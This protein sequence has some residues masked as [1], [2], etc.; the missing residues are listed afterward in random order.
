MPVISVGDYNAYQFNSG[1]DDSISVI[2]GN[3]TPDDQI[4]VDQSPDLVNP[5]LSNLTETL[6]AAERYSFI[7][8]GRRRGSTIMS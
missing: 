2:K 7:F 1:Y 6:P 5:N 4:V 8:E 3:P